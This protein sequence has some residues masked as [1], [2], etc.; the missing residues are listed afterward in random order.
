[1]K[2]PISAVIDTNVVLAILSWHDVATAIE[3][4]PESSL[5][6]PE[7]QGRLQKAR[8][9]FFLSLLMNE[10]AWTTL[11][12]QKEVMRIVLERAPPEEREAETAF[13]AIWL[14]FIKDELLPRWTFGGDP[15][16]EAQKR[17]SAVDVYLVEAAAA[18]QVPLISWEGLGLQGFDD[19]RTIPREAARLGVD[20]ATP[21][22]FLLRE[23]YDATYPAARFLERWDARVDLFIRGKRRKGRRGRRQYLQVMRDFFARMAGNDW[24]P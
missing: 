11:V 10:R 15:T 23:R 14:H 4:A 19:R 6:S 1:M 9:S 16:G 8:S 22:E 18:L 12:P 3:T 5:E 21:H 7:V 24:S 13:V 2:S 20:L 17:G